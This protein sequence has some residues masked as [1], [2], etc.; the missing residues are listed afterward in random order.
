M[1]C[2]YFGKCASCVLYDKSYDEQLNF[3]LQREKERFSDFTTI[4][5]DIIKSEEKAFRN[6]AEF[7]IWWEK[8]ENGSE[9]RLTKT[10]QTRMVGNSVCPQLSRALVEANFKHENI[11]KGA[12]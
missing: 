9:I 11:Y 2:E 8:D 5:F 1:N 12:A 6:R 7:R 4:D 10:E 3:K